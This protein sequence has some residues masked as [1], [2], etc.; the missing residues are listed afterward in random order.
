MIDNERFP[1]NAATMTA[2]FDGVGALALVLLQ[3]MP[4]ADRDAAANDFA[5]L[6][7]QAEAQGNLTLE[8]FLMDMYRA[9][10]IS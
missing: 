10:K 6:A 3:R 8:S 4:P 5:R 7:R 9:A 1:A 2:L